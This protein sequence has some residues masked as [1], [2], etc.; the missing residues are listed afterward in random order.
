MDSFKFFSNENKTKVMM[1]G[2][3]HNVGPAIR[4]GNSAIEIV[5]R[6]NILGII[7]DDDIRKLVLRYVSCIPS[8]FVYHFM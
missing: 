2:L 3:F 7:L 8:T 5:D 4:V 6:M 1:F